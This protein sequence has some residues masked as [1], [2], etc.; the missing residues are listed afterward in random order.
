MNKI[1]FVTGNKNKVKEANKIIG[2]ILVVADIN[3]HEIQSLDIYKVVKKKA[4]EAYRILKK[5]LIVEDV[6]M[7]FA[8]W[9]GFPGPLVK[10]LHESGNHSFDL[11][12]KMLENFEDKS[13]EAKAVIGFHDGKKVHFIEGVMKGKFTAK[14]GSNGWGFDPYFIPE[15]Y[16]KTVGELEEGVKNAIS[17]R[18]KAFQNF[19]KYLDSQSKQKKI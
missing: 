3:L 6:G 15:G 1:T 9:N 19:K 14:K 7:Y 12:V 13:T 10:Y 5:P 16:N 8:S 11:A 4:E 18:A 17:H 2:D